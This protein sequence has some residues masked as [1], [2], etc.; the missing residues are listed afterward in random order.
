LAERLCA[1]LVSDSQRDEL[2]GDLEEECRLLAERRDVG[3]ARRWY[4]KQTFRSIPSMLQRRVDDFFLY[5]T[6]RDRIT[7]PM[8]EGA[9]NTSR[10]GRFF[11][12]FAVAW[13]ASV[14]WL[15][16]PD[17]TGGQPANWPTVS[18]PDGADYTAY[19]PRRSGVDGAVLLRPDE[20]TAPYISDELVHRQEDRFMLILFGVP[21]GIAMSA[22]LWLAARQ[23][24]FRPLTRE[25]TPLERAAIRDE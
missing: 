16:H 3:F 18:L 23:F 4:W 22:L 10:I 24:R 9:P 15:L 11:F 13:I 8:I 19:L 2:L 1:L 12:V 17:P 21:F 5:L 20:G 7:A 6:K 14:A 25:S